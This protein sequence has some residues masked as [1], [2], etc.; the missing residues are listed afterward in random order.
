P[1]PKP[2]AAPVTP[3][4]KATEQEL[5]RKAGIYRDPLTE[6]TIKL[7]FKEGKLIA[8]IGPGFQLV[9]MSA[10]DF[11]VIG[12]PVKVS[13]EIAPDGSTKR[14]VVN[15]EGNPKP[16]VLEPVNAPAPTDLAQYVGRYYSQE[17]DT[18]YTF[19]VKEGKLVLQRKKFED[20]YLSSSG[21]DNFSDADLGTIKFTRDPG[22]AVIGFELN[23]GRVRHLKF[24]RQTN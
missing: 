7:E 6:E 2:G 12:A 1:P 10:T 14:M 5:Q 16:K 13:F 8:A 4:Y 22:K 20:S 24:A 19:A 9:P 3:P 15:E 18:T 21:P 17:L 11:T 23:A